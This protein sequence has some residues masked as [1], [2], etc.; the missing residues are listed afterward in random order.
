MAT[1]V[2]KLVDSVVRHAHDIIRM[3]FLLISREYFIALNYIILLISPDINLF[4]PPNGYN[5]SHFLG[6]SFWV[7][8]TGNTSNLSLS[9]SSFAKLSHLEFSQALT[10]TEVPH[11]CS[12][13][14]SSGN[15][16]ALCLIKA[17]SSNF[18]PLK[19]K[20]NLSNLLHRVHLRTLT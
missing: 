7:K 9:V 16:S 4:I 2:N 13:V 8:G 10:V 19:I 15:E 18:S 11:S 3:A 17:A 14:T 12:T 1:S 6:L 20:L 5:M